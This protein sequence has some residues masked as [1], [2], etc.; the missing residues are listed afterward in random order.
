MPLIRFL[1]QLALFA[2]LTVLLLAAGEM[3]VRNLDNPYRQ[4]DRFMTRNADKI[5]TLILGHSQAYYGLNPALM[6]DSAYSLAMVSQ[7]LP[8]DCA[9][10]HQYSPSL[11]S[12]RRVIVPVTFTSIF[13]QPLEDE[14]EWWRITYYNLYIGLDDASIFSPYGA[15]VWH[16]P[17]Y[18]GK[19]AVATGLKKKGLNPDSLGHGTEY[20]LANRK[21]DWQKAAG[22]YAGTHNKSID[23]S[24][25]MANMSALRKINSI[26]RSKNAD[27]ILVTPPTWWRY[28][29]WLD[30]AAYSR[31]TTELRTFC[32]DTGSVWLDYSAD[33]RF[34]DS[35]FYDVCHLSSDFGAE[36]FTKILVHDL[37]SLKIK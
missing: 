1:K 37:N 22:W 35:D 2:L 33:P 20:T 15:E 32:D 27:L 14:K 18:A 24:R 30:S 36:K 19:L 3:T 7:T 26:C 9:L 5:T 6:P 16:L 13:S 11:T 10:L 4:K 34:V 28:R 29:Q 23:Y 8:I 25:I 21:Q 31:M 12:L 17:S